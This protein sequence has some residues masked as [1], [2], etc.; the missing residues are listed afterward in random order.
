MKVSIDELKK[1]YLETKAHEKGWIWTY[2]VRRP[3]SYYLAIFFLY[4]DISAN[5]VTLLFLF[6][7]VIGSLLLALGDYIM[8]ILGALLIELAIILDCVD[9]NI[10]RVRG[11]T[12]LGSVLDVWSGE[13]ILVL[14]LFMLGVGLSG[15]ANE[16]MITLYILNN[17]ISTTNGNIFLYIGSLTAIVSL[18]SW[19]ARN[20]W[21]VISK[22]FDDMKPTINGNIMKKLIENIFH[23]SGAYSLTMLIAAIF[24]ILDL[25]LLLVG[26]AYCV[27]LFVIMYTIIKKAYSLDKKYINNCFVV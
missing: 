12:T 15:L 13:I 18:A 23:Y 21:R 3:I 9:G 16:N 24:N 7:G 19:A 1:R 6:T 20:S 27:N 26:S 14:S 10:A 25:F 5:K 11:S 8:F 4:F 2:Y 22:N 17:I